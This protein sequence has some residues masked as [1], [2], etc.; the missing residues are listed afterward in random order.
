MVNS[1]AKKFKAAHLQHRDLL[2]KLFEGLSATGDFAWSL[3]MASVPSYTQQSE[4]VPLPDDM[5]VDN[6]QVSIAEVDYPWEGEAIPSDDSPISRVREHT[7]SSTS[8]SRTPAS[9]V[10]ARTQSNRKSLDTAVQPLEPTELVQYLISAFTGINNPY[11]K[12]WELW[13]RT[14]SNITCG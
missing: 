9:Q 2:D 1:E 6:T 14:S 5:Q 12:F 3:G 7:P 11:V 13:E 10:S 8:R 4:Y